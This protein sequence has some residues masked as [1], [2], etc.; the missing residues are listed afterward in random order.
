MRASAAVALVALVVAGCGGSSKPSGSTA[1]RTA[2]TTSTPTATTVTREQFAAKLDS[3]CKRG[4]ALVASTQAEVTKAMNAGDYTAAATATEKISRDV[5]PLE[6]ELA[7]LTPPPSEQAAFAR[8]TQANARISGLRVRLAK[9]LRAND[10]AQLREL[11]ALA[12]S[13]QKRRTTAAIDLGT[14]ECG[15]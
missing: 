4:N 1:A 15:S 14:T 6:A 13:E 10:V 8:Y 7:A 5:M 2:T 12:V 11:D 9:A 3:I